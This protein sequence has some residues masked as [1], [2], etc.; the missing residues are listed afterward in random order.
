MSKKEQQI[1]TVEAHGETVQISAEALAT[2]AGI[3]ARE[4]EG[5]AGI[6]ATVQGSVM[7]LVGMRK[8][9]DGVRIDE[10]EK[11]LI[12]SVTITLVYGHSAPQVAANVQKE[13]LP[14]V[15]SMTGV[16]LAAVNVRVADVAFP[17]STGE[18]K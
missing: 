11:G 5:V 10:G 15:E 4:V 12:L 6:N 17:I 8:P 7:S 18:K 9:G 13:I 16:R 2:V 14:A 3:A 1:F